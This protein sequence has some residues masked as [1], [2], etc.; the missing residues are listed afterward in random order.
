MKNVRHVH[1]TGITYGSSTQSKTDRLKKLQVGQRA[2]ERR[3][4]E[5][6]IRE[7]IRSEEIRRK[8]SEGHDRG[9]EKFKMELGR[10]P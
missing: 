7:R 3:M 10:P 5:G 6:T 2:M 8:T 9:G 1:A 4:L